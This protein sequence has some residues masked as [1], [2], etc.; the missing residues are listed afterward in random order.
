MKNIFLF[1]C[2]FVS[3]ILAQETQPVL[4]PVYK[5]GKMGY[6]NND[7]KL[8]IKCEL[9][10]E[11]WYEL[12]NKTEEV[13]AAKNDGKYYLVKPTGALVSNTPYQS[14]HFDIPNKL[15][16]AELVDDGKK[17]FDTKKV[18][19]LNY[20][21]EQIMPNQFDCNYFECGYNFNNDLFV[22]TKNKKRGAINRKG[23]II[24]EP[25]Y[26][27]LTDFK[28]GYAI[29]E[30]V[31]NGKFGVVAQ[32]NKIL[33]SAKYERISNVSEDGY[34]FAMKN[35]NTGK[36]TVVVNMAGKELKD[37]GK[38]KLSYVY[39]TQAVYKNNVAVMQDT[40]SKL[41][42]LIDRM[43]NI[44]S[45][46]KYTGFISLNEENIFVF[47]INGTK[48]ENDAWFERTGGIWV[49]VDGTTGKEIGVPFKATKVK[50]FQNGMAAFQLNDKW[51]FINKNGTV[52]IPPKF[53]ET[54]DGFDQELCRMVD[55]AKS[56]GGLSEIGY[57]N[58]KG[59]Y[60]WPVQK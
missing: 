47:N 24:I 27:D 11:D 26:E 17:L 30:S 49:L 31:E 43:G 18:V 41:F 45:K 33:I 21:G 36:L 38:F 2:F 32:N 29:F 16:R 14:L 53:V 19:W 56:F 39:T 42:A 28:N 3:K 4:Y 40:V 15:I 1:F 10:P 37:L 34:F 50:P 6:M 8:R 52:S 5:N 59:E 13:F 22:F 57:I 9:E 44:I 46:P 51:G 35:T 25:K 58:K 48:S 12:K 55:K 7:A 23:D 60:I 54:P 20:K